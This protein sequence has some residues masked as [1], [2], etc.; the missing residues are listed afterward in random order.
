MHFPL[1]RTIQFY[2]FRYCLFYQKEFVAGNVLWSFGNA[3]QYLSVQLT[4]GNQ[5]ATGVYVLFITSTETTLDDF[6]W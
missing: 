2:V 4:F 3:D 5:E 1:F 6:N